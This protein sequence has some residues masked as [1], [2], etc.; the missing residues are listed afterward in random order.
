MNTHL[1][2][3]QDLLDELSKF[4]KAQEKF[5]KLPPSHKREYINYLEESKKPETRVRRIGKIILNLLET[6]KDNTEN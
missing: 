5:N 6:Q 1:K 3:P 4:P 2:I